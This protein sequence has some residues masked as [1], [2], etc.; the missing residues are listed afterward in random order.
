MQGKKIVRLAYG[1]RGIDLPL[2]PDWNVT[3]VEPKRVAPLADPAAA[4][5]EA[6][7]HPLSGRPLK[8]MVLPGLKVGI[9]FNDITR[10]TPND[11]IIN[12]ILS[13]L[14]HVP[15]DSVTLFNAL[16]THRPNTGEELRD[17]LG[18]ELVDHYRIIQNN[19]F[20]RNTQVHIG[21]TMSGNEVW[22]NQEVLSCDIRILTGFI[23]PHFFAGFS[24]GG[25]ALMPGMAGLATIMKNHDAGNIGNPNASWGITTGNPV[26]EEVR[27]VLA[28]TGPAFL[29][30]VTLD[31]TKKITGIFAGD[32]FMAHDAGMEFVRET[33]MI[34]VEKEFDMVVTTNSGYPLDLNL[35]QAVK[36]M[37]AAAR[38][39]RQGGT[40]LSVADCWDGIPRHG[41]FGR[42]LKEYPD[43][44]EM[45][46]AIHSPGFAS[47][48]QWQAQLLAL[49]R[50]KAEVY[51]YSENLSQEEL[52]NVQLR[53]CHQIG[54]MIESHRQSYGQDLSI[55]LLPEG[56]Q[57]IPYLVEE[58]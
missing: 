27:E 15:K 17:M 6:L 33:A 29:V 39:V 34:P 30:N 31:R 44:V 5:T 56:P 57:T 42:M 40:I 52:E 46:Q 24:G 12:S 11:L 23:E 47:L 50:Q 38:I 53:K 18:D 49:I 37:S 22:M 58:M 14:S 48:D 26:W 16:G 8:E 13:E 45:L 4:V 51:L 21:T 32:P 10:P 41:N 7:Q 2:N 35:Y 55:C 9:V 36:G 25:K 43:P 19:A 28:M 54:E 1:K 3:V 20:D